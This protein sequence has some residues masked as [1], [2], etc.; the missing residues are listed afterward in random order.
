[1]APTALR[2]VQ[3]NGTGSSSGSVAAGSA[4][5]VGW[6]TLRVGHRAR[7]RCMPY[8]RPERRR[9]PY[10]RATYRTLLVLRLGSG[11]ER[12][13]GRVVNASRWPP[14]AA[15]VHAVPAAGK[16]PTAL[17]LQRNGLPILRLGRGGQR[18]IGRV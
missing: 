3:R 18:G 11:W 8:R 6:S 14:S 1:K 7:L 13:I 10:V 9:P 12:G 4:V 17:R 5:S 2:F 16:A 15:A